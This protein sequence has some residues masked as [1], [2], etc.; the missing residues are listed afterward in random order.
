MSRKSA[1]SRRDRLIWTIGAAEVDEA[2]WRLR[3]AGRDVDI[4]QKPMELLLA[5]LHRN[6][7]VVTKDEL[8]DL[9]WPGVTVVPASLPTALFKFQ[10]D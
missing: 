1:G 3:V 7:E 2:S 10:P 6:G 9:V 8:L 4:E 5:L